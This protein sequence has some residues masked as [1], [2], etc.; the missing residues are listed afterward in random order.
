MLDEFARC[1]ID[2]VEDVRERF[3]PNFYFGCKAD[4]PINAW[5]FDACK[6]P[7][8]A[9]LRAIFSSDIGHWD[10]PDMREVTA[11]AYELV[12]HGHIDEADFRD[13]VFGNP[14]ALWTGTNPDFFKGT[15][16]EAQCSGASSKGK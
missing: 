8:G 1:G 14:H 4:D 9:R 11:E 15:L 2:T 5:A 6:N 3:V 16:V 12:E 7:L 10:V 13:F